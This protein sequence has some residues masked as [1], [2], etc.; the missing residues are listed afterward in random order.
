MEL[1]CNQKLR[2]YSRILTESQG[3]CK[4]QLNCCAEKLICNLVYGL[5]DPSHS[6]ADGRKEGSY[7]PLCA[8]CC[9]IHRELEGR[10]VAGGVVALTS[11]AGGPCGGTSPWPCAPGPGPCDHLPWG[12]VSC[13]PEPVPAEPSSEKSLVGP[14]P[15]LPK[16]TWLHRLQ[17][18][19]ATLL[20]DARL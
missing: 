12:A 4:C 17:Q 14:V 11:L 13:W 2:T 3:P 8:H 20:H 1:P 7:S 15:T 18:R 6:Q 16:A 5:T 9:Y 19:C 10:A